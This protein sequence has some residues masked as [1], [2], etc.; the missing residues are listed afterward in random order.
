MGRAKG[1]SNSSKSALIKATNNR[2]KLRNPK[3][4][5]V[6][7]RTDFSE[8][9]KYN[10]KFPN[11]E[12][13]VYYAIDRLKQGD[14]SKDI[15]LDLQQKINSNT[16]KPYSRKIVE[17]IVT[18]AKSLVDIYYKQIL[19]NGE[20]LHVVRYNQIITELM[21][22]DY[23]MFE[24]KPHIMKEVMANDLDNVLKALFQKETLLGMHR[25]T[26]RVVMNNQVNII[27]REERLNQKKQIR[28]EI[29]VEELTL[30]E[31]IELLD[32]IKKCKRTQNETVG[33]ILR[34]KKEKQ[35]EVYEDAE[36]EE[37][38]NTDVMESYKKEEKKQEG[39]TLDKLQKI[40]LEKSKK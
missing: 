35:E 36:Y 13:E 17:Q 32:L 5:E 38:P 30:E 24:H 16:G 8:F 23:S 21:N 14:V 39:T 27:Q 7:N 1:G 29:D 19:Y 18:T 6:E 9:K 15:R 25:E 40:L 22:K 10:G 3:L 28:S 2:E 20:K 11:F 31:Q 33:I 26:F 37:I 4:V 34:D 12:K